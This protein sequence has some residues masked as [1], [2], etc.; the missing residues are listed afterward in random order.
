M[1]DKHLLTKLFIT[2]LFETGMF[3]SDSIYDVG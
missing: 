1:W 3:G 2:K